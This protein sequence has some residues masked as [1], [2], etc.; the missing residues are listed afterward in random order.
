MMYGTG[1]QHPDITYM[2]KYG[3]DEGIEIECPICG[4]V[5]ETFYKRDGEIVGCDMCVEKVD[6]Y[7]EMEDF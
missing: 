2:E 3:G 4:Y 1:L 6:A 5:C 7:E